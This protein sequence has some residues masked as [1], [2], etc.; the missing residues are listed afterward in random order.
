[1]PPTAYPEQSLPFNE[2]GAPW[3]KVY[4]V[5]KLR[6][7]W[8]QATALINA[9]PPGLSNLL[10]AFV[11]KSEVGKRL[12]ASLTKEF[13]PL[14]QGKPLMFVMFL[15]LGLPETHQFVKR[16]LFQAY[17]DI[18]K[19][20]SDTRLIYPVSW[21]LDREYTQPDAVAEAVPCQETPKAQELHHD[22]TK[23]ILDLLDTV[24]RMEGQIKTLQ[25]RMDGQGERGKLAVD[26][27]KEEL[28][29][30]ISDA[31][32]ELDVLAAEQQTP[33]SGDLPSNPFAALEQVK[34]MLKAAGFKGT[35]T[36]TIE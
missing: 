30:D 12:P 6:T 32:H 26:A 18:T 5:D 29:G 10:T 31:F 15:H 13:L 19:K 24:E 1:M 33:V 22:N 16:A 11:Q 20:G 36:L 17:K 7:A 27:L 25:E 28:R 34:A 2:V 3:T 21:F 35:L 14:F 9:A 8:A 4:S 23:A